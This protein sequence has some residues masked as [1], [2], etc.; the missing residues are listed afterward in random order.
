[1]AK[2]RLKGGWARRGWL[3]VDG[4]AAAPGGSS[5]PRIKSR[6]STRCVTR[7]LGVVSGAAQ[8]MWQRASFDFVDAGRSLYDATWSVGQL[9]FGNGSVGVNTPELAQYMALHCP[10]IPDW[11]PYLRYDMKAAHCLPGSCTNLTNTRYFNFKV[12]CL[13]G[14]SRTVPTPRHPA[15]SHWLAVYPCPHVPR[16][17]ANC[18][19]L[20]AS[21]G[22]G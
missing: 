9:R 16:W 14:G 15:R 2:R 19:H 18:V 7:Q 22:G 5:A 3:G 10:C 8:V 11:K 17:C 1:M 21:A 4:V 6:F 12:V 13:V 20:R